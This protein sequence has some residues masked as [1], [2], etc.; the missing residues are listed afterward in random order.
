[1][2]RQFAS[3]E[4]E[5]ARVSGQWIDWIREGRL[6]MPI[7]VPEANRELFSLFLGLQFLRTAE[8]RD[9]FLLFRNVCEIGALSEVDK[10]RLHLELLW[11]MT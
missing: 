2:E 8:S 9:M 3:L 1:M 10:R 6:G 11:T 5:V 4:Y 7:T